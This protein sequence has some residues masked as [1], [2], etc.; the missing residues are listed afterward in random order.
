LRIDLRVRAERGER[1][2]Y[3]YGDEFAELW[4]Q[5]GHGPG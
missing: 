3:D 5:S 4:A 1:E 2:A